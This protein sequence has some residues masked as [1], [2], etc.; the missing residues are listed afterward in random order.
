MTAQEPPKIEFPCRYPIKV[1]GRQCDALHTQVAAVFR[2]HATDF[3]ADAVSMKASRGGK[4]VSL[5]VV[6]EATGVDQLERLH[7][8]LM[9]TGLVSM[10]I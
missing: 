8:D 2:R 10:V 5:T 1:V 3:S 7:A 6:I 9:A 4:F